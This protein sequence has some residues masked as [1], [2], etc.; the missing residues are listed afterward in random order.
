MGILVIWPEAL[1]FTSTIAIG[2]TLPVACASMTMVR[3]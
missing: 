3:R 2:S 1:D